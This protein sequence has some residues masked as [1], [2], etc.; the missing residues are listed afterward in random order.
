VSQAPQ[1]RQFRL[2]R[3]NELIFLLK[4]TA[5]GWSDDN[6]ARL[7][8]AL[9]FYTLLSL[10]PL[11]VVVVAVAG[12]AYGKQAAQGQIFWQIRDLVGSEGARAIQG[13]LEGAYKPGTGALATGL[14]VLTLA[15]GASSVVGEL[16]EARTRFGMC[17]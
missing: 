16:R 3:V 4:E 14:G 12:I 8:A 15:L 7:G 17:P 6:I 11:L 1:S 9:A 5:G 10:A 13:L 2:L